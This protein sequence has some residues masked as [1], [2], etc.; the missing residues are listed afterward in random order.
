MESIIITVPLT[1]GVTTR[2]ST[3]SHLEMTNWNSADAMISVVKVAGPPSTSAVMQKGIAKA[4]V[5]I[6]STAPAPAGPSR[7]TWSRVD[8]PTTSSEANTIQIR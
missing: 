8:T 2:R 4:A 6:G 5:N 3:N 1:I 7:L